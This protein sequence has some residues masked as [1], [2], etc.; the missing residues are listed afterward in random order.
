MANSAST[1]I[2]QDLDLNFGIH[3]VRKD[4][5][6]RRNAEAVIRA[7]VN[8]IQTNHYEVPFH[9]EIGCNIRKLL[10]ENISEFTAR[11]ISRFITETITNFEPRVTI[12]SL[13]VSPNI[14]LNA[15]NVR[16]SVFVATHINAVTVDFLLKRIR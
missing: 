12:Q 6:P 15:Y 10:F 11:D 3:P 4:L 16:L 13:V 8:L 5:V 9:P 2:Y 1:V 7:V 14:D